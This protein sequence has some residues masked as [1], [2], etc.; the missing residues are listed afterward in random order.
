MCYYSAS[1]ANGTVLNER[2][3]IGVAESESPWGPYRDIGYPLVL[4]YK[5]F[6]DSGLNGSSEWNLS[7]IKILK[8]LKVFKVSKVLKV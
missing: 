1:L 4:H 3:S 5:V 7:L 8:V 2:H 6:V